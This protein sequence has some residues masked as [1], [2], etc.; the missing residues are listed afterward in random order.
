MGYGMREFILS[1]GTL[2]YINPCH[3]VELWEDPS[4]NFTYLETIVGK[5][6]LRDDLDTN[7]RRL[8]K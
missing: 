5:H 6:C 3:V 8:N 4:K 1:D 2:R 7:L